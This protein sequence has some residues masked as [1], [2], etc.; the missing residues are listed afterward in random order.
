MHKAKACIISCMDFRFHDKIQTYLKDKDYLGKC[1]EIAIAGS[2]RDF[3]FPVEEAD[4]KYIWKQVGLSIKL[5]DPDEIIFI[6]HQDCGGYAQ[7]GTIPNE[8]P[9]DEDIAEHKKFFEKLK[10]KFAEKYPEKIVKFLY[11]PL[12]GDIIEVL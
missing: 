1:D 7:D 12:E 6:D 11:A 4:G 10:V 9:R 3:I 2:T 8:L 5:H